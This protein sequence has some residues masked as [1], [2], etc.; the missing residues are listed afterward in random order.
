MSFNLGVNV[1]ETDGKTVP[2]LQAAPTSVAAFIGVTERGLPD[3]AVRVTSMAQFQARFGSYLAGSFTAYALNGFF[4]NGGR[5]AY[6]CR[7]TG[8][9]TSAA[10]VTLDDRQGTAAPALEIAAGYRGEPDPGDWGE[11][12][13]VDVRNDPRASTQLA[14][15]T[16]ADAT[17]AELE[18]LLGFEVGSVV[19]LTDGGTTHYRKI[20]RIDSLS[21]TIHWD[22]SEQI[23]AVLPA[24]TVA[25]S[26]EF[27]LIVRYRATPT[28]ELEAVEDWRNLSMERDTADYAV[29]R[30]NHPNTGSN[31]IMATN[32][33]AGGAPVGENT[34]AIGSN[35]ALTDGTDAAPGSPDY[36]GS[37]ADYTGLH[38][39]DTAQV[40]LIAAP[41][42]HQL[43]EAARDAVMRGCMDYCALRGDAMFV[44]GA[45]DIE[46]TQTASD[47]VKT[48]KTFAANFHGRKVYGA[49]Y[50]G[51]LQ[52]VDPIGSGPAPS[53]LIPPDGHVMG[54]Y[55]RTDRERGIFKAPAGIE[56]QVR[57]AGAVTVTMTDAEH[58]DLVRTG[59]VNGVRPTPGYGITVAA[60]RTLSGDTRWWFVSTRLL[61]NF[62]KAT[63]RDGLRFVRQ[64]PHTGELRQRVRL[65]VVTPFLMGLYRQG[66]FGLGVPPEAV[67]TVKCDAENNP[68]ERVDQGYFYI[69]V[70]FYP[71]KPAEIIILTVGQQPSGASASEA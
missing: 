46:G 55:A 61:F 13:R 7:V 44:G 28:A 29:D 27:R 3:R 6:I 70:Y 56:A 43:V 69:E 18:T 67:F 71:V 30:I 51:W 1:V 41:D 35:I 25:V 48:T 10:S 9:T 53:R 5:T 40:Q 68:P 11:R 63:L 64:E 26:S 34:P 39:F 62:V 47:F 52:V 12:L 8:D 2:S 66:A 24:G 32:V 38:A 22:A 16:S 14:A 59:R 21:R 33:T 17:S 31:Y 57:G 65:N 37:A 49:L 19:R 45:P 36:I 15:P 60:S 54:V 58:T 4:L 42:A 20:T 50:A 23:A